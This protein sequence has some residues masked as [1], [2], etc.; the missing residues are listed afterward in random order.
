MIN[1]KCMT[2]CQ[3]LYYLSPFDNTLDK[4]IKENP[5]AVLLN[6]YILTLSAVLQQQ[7]NRK[8]KMM[9]ICLGF[10]GVDCGE[11]FQGIVKTLPRSWCPGGRERSMERSCLGWLLWKQHICPSQES[12]P[13][14]TAS[15]WCQKLPW[16]SQDLRAFPLRSGDTV[17][18]V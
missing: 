7:V 17:G 18:A 10:A 15:S 11:I 1:F 14:D 8:G 2:G 13:W 6:C 12:R 16:G 3:K 5:S 9:Q 4:S